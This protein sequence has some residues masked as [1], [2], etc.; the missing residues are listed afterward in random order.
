MM[1]QQ[2]I[3]FAF[4]K[5]SA[6]FT[7]ILAHYNLKPEGMGVE[8]A[9]LCPFHDEHKPSCK[10]E[11]ERRIFHCF[12]CG[13]KGN[14][15]E[16]VALMEGNRADL[17]AAALKLAAICKIPLAPPRGGSGRAASGARQARKARSAP[18]RSRAGKRA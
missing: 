7:T 16:F 5:G 12:G 15:L 14:I 6:T 18:K 11:L 2:Y 3:D 8:R 17:R 10:V 4:V 13:A 9:V 1:P